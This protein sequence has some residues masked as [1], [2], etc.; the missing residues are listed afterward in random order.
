MASLAQDISLGGFPAQERVKKPCSGGVLPFGSGDSICI[1]LWR[2][3]HVPKVKGFK[4]NFRYTENEE[5]VCSILN[6]SGMKRGANRGE[7]SSC[8]PT[9]PQSWGS[10]WGE[11]SLGWW[12]GAGDKPAR[13]PCAAGT[14]MPVGKWCWGWLIPPPGAPALFAVERKG[15]F[16]PAPGST[17]R[18]MLE[19]KQPSC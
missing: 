3:V 1:W 4:K 18:Q 2:K 6:T 11:G 9:H 13:S 14:T 17:C 16:G 19:N 15:I 12:W 10:A 5:G 8:G 7:S